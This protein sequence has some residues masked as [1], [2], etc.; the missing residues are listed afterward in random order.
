VKLPE[1]TPYVLTIVIVRGVTKGGA[2]CKASRIGAIDE[3]V[4][5]TLALLKETDPEVETCSCMLDDSELK[6][7]GVNKECVLD[8]AHAKRIAKKWEMQ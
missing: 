5:K 3:C 4:K 6:E 1:L 7:I 2:V 8:V